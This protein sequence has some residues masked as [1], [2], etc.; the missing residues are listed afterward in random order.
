MPFVPTMKFRLGKEVRL[1]LT[2]GL[3]PSAR[4]SNSDFDFV[5]GLSSSEQH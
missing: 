4:S 1:S 5:L 3:A 2:L